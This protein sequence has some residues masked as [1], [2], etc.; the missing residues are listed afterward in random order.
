MSSLKLPSRFIQVTSII[1]A[2]KR[3]HFINSIFIFS[4]FC[5]VNFLLFPDIL[6]YFRFKNNIL[7]FGYSWKII[8]A[9][10]KHPC[11]PN[12]S[13][14][15]SLNSPTGRSIFDDSHSSIRINCRHYDGPVVFRNFPV[16]CLT[17]WRSN[18][19]LPRA[20]QS[21]GHAI[22]ELLF[23]LQAHTPD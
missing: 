20:P 21:E 9:C 17:G 14:K 7:W 4:V 1:N 2:F 15:H 22:Y 19:R 10:S 11:K 3:V 5:K 23:G 6:V 12:S 13:R 8:H 16:G 18:S